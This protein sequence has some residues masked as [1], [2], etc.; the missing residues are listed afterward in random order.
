MGKA[1]EQALIA[2]AADEVPIGCVIVFNDKIIG[3][4]FNQRNNQKC[5]TSHAEILAIQKACKH[6]RD[7]RLEGCSLFVT[8]EPCPMCAGAII[9][10]RIHTVVFATHNIKAGCAGSV[11]NIL[12]N[13]RFNHRV[14][15]VSGVME[16]ECTLL[17]QQFFKMMR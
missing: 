8:V 1:Y 17:M 14:H 4:G 7:W 15:V 11:L 12:N 16:R 3:R 9:Q 6:M 2:F 13:P 10:A 5:A